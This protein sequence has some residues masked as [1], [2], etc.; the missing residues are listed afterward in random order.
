MQSVQCGTAVTFGN[1]DAGHGLAAA[2]EHAVAPLPHQLPGTPSVDR[3]LPHVGPQAAYGSSLGARLHCGHDDAGEQEQLPPAPL[4]HAQPRCA[5]ICEQARLQS[6]GS[7][8]FL[9]VV[10][11][12]IGGAGALL[13]CARSRAFGGRLGSKSHADKKLHRTA[14]ARGWRRHAKHIARRSRKA[15]PPRPRAHPRAAPWHRSARSHRRGHAR[16]TSAYTGMVA[17]PQMPDA[18]TPRFI[19]MK[20]FSPHD[21]PHEFFTIQVSAVY[22]QTRIAEKAKHVD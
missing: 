10:G 13:T 17:M 21:G 11:G 20:P 18:P 6:H 7:G 12:G 1:G 15:R 19:S 4:Q 8:G 3:Q 2:P 14:A 22:L 16:L 5:H 9:P